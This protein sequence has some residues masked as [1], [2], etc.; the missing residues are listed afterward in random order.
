MCAIRR[1]RQPAPEPW[2]A[3]SPTKRTH[4]TACRQNETS[5][6]CRVEPP[7]LRPAATEQGAASR[8]RTEDLRIARPRRSLRFIRRGRLPPL[9]PCYRAALRCQPEEA[10]P[11]VIQHVCLERL[12]GPRAVDL[13]P[14]PL[15]LVAVVRRVLDENHLE[16]G[17]CP[18]R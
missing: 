6:R 3:A 4:T 9:L 16:P 5:G 11:D 18:R 2:P 8:N 1:L 7:R 17:C 15:M 10:V 13:Q 14:V 12:L